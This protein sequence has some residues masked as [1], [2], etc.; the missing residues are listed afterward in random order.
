MILLELKNTIYITRIKKNENFLI[1]TFYY[2]IVSPFIDLE[3]FP[4]YF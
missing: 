3:L 4:I 1:T 2:S